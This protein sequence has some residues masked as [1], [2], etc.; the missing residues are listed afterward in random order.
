MASLASAKETKLLI[1]LLSHGITAPRY[2]ENS[3]YK[4]TN[5]DY[6]EFPGELT[7]EGFFQME[8]IGK[9]LK[10][11]FKDDQKFLPNDFRPEMFYHKSYRDE[12]S[13]ISAY[14][15]MLGAY[16]DSI[17]WIQF[18]NMGSDTPDPPFDRDDEIEVRKALRLS[19]NPSDVNTREMTIWSENDG[20]TFLNDPLN[21]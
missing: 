8:Q 16:P 14:T 21:N 18:I 1:D 19:T 4:V 17:S 3:L 11:E 9:N 20:R 15:T 10:K 7:N 13:V 12:P 6:P 5:N 2:T